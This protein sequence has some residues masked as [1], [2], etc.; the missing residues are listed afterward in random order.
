MIR[1]SYGN[2][3][4]FS[5]SYYDSHLYLSLIYFSYHSMHIVASF[6]FY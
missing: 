4:V 6:F 5:M 1:S 3:Y 2:F